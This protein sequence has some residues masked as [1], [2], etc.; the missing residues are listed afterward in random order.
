MKKGDL[1]KG[2]LFF[3]VL[4]LIISSLVG[5]S[6]ETSANKKVTYEG[7]VKKI[8]ANNCLACHG[9]TSPTMEEF[10]A[11]VEKYK[12]MMKGPRMD[13]Y[14]NLLVLVNGNE[15]GA[16][17]RRLDDGANREDGKPGNMYT[18][19]GQNDEER[20]KNLATLKQWVGNWTLKR[21]NELTDEDKKAFLVPE[22]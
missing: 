17:M 3:A 16:F 5:C 11:D 19:L 9:S 1:F 22:K 4:S 8:I 18:H 21:T 13:S 20:Q 12:A 15:A 10:D 7:Q 14:E 6:S 2:L